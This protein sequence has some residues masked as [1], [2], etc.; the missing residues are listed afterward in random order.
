MALRRKVALANPLRHAMTKGVCTGVC[1]KY[2]SITNPTS[3]K[4]VIRKKLDDV[5]GV[6]VDWNFITTKT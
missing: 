3:I 6:I 1:T 5:G 4:V 2:A